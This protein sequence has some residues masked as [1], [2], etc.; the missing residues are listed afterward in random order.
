MKT[1]YVLGSSMDLANLDKSFFENNVTI[2]VNHAYKRSKDVGEHIKYLVTLDNS[3][4]VFDFLS[5]PESTQTIKLVPADY[6]V[7]IRFHDL[8][9]KA[10]K[11]GRKDLVI[12]DRH[13]FTG[14]FQPVVPDNLEGVK[15]DV[16]DHTIFTAI[17]LA[18]SMK[19]EEIVLR[20]VSLAG[21]RYH[22]PTHNPDRYPYFEAVRDVL[23]V[24]E[25]VLR[26]DHGISLRNMSA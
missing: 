1:V 13:D 18:V 14:K 8:Y 9:Q 17:S 12:Y 24:A 15:L 2:G 21:A 5:S 10:K 26:R 25:I 22:E 7:D 3:M 16:L 4:V 23:F 11:E 19:P 20:G 6:M